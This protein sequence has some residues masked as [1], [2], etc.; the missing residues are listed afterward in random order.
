MFLV[1]HNSS[2][3]LCSTIRSYITNTFFVFFY[4]FQVRPVA[5]DEMF[6]V[7]RSGKRKSKYASSADFSICFVILFSFVCLKIFR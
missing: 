3:E 7:L 6:K 5:E 2:S 4:F 1:V